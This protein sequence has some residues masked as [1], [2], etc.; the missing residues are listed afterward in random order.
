MYTKK[1]A[2]YAG[3]NTTIEPTDDVD[4]DEYEEEDARGGGRG[5]GGNGGAVDVRQYF[6]EL[7]QKDAAADVNPFEERRTKTIADRER[8]TYNER[9][10]KLQLSPG[11]RYETLEFTI[12]YCLSSSC[13]IL[14]HDHF[15]LL[16]C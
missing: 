13:R 7:A 1:S 2:K 8:G 3:Y 12:C 10:Q 15:E 5:G 14:I 6:D 11:V 16:T 9:R 4:E